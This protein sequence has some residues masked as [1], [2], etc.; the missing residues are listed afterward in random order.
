[1]GYLSG[2]TTW[3]IVI[4]TFIACCV[5]M[6]EVSTIVVGVGRIRGWKSTLIGSGTGLVILAAIIFILG[7][8]IS[9]IPIHWL[10]LV[11][12]ALLLTFGLN[13]LR[14]AILAYVYDK[15]ESE[16]DDYKGRK[17]SKFG[18]SD[19]YAF[20][21]AFKGTLLEGLEIVFIVL[22]FGAS[23]GN[24]WPAL[25]GG[26]AAVVIISVAAIF[27]K[28][29]IADIPERVLKFVVGVLLA[30]FG[31]FWASE[32]AYANWP[33]GDWFLI[34][35]VAYYLAL[36]IGLVAVGRKLQERSA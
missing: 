2:G 28:N 34:I 9:N 7:S 19:W 32:G 12:G 14:K 6:I 21:V 16:D 35:L 4:S 24:L 26:V 29:W 20:T 25:I 15:K 11:V 17:E 22:T 36:A 30:T 5:E 23:S 10:R 3:G 8:Q 27:A 18:V 33:F 1:M 13:W 31:T